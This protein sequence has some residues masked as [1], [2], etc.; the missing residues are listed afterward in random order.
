MRSTPFSLGGGRLTS[1]NPGCLPRWVCVLVP[2]QD[3]ATERG[4]ALTRSHHE[5]PLMG[6]HGT[7]QG[8]AAVIAAELEIV[9]TNVMTAHDCP[10]MLAGITAG[11]LSPQRLVQHRIDLS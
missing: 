9:G 8:Q 10:A 2:Q 3:P 5:Y 1:K 6:V 11:T 4:M 7:G